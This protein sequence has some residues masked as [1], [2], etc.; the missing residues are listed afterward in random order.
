MPIIL[1]DVHVPI[2]PKE[3]IC[4]SLVWNIQKGCCREIPVCMCVYVNVSI[5]APRLRLV[6]GN[7]PWEG[8]VE[9]FRS[10][11]WGTVCDDGWDGNDA[12][13]VCRQLGYSTNGKLC[14]LPYCNLHL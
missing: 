5:G 4:S 8:R 9:V 10:G 14:T 13:V 7:D 6:N 12:A 2:I 3:I 11:S 1:S